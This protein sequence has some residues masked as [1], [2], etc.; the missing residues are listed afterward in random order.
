MMKVGNTPRPVILTGGIMH[1]FA[2]FV[3]LSLTACATSPI[4]INQASPVRALANPGTA[5]LSAS[6]VHGEPHHQA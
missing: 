3:A 6:T 5:V 4:A 2:V 1:F